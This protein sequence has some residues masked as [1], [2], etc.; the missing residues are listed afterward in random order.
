MM[1]KGI[2][3]FYVVLFAILSL[4]A[5]AGTVEGII[6]DSLSNPLPFCNVYLK[7]TGYTAVSNEIGK[8]MLQ[9]PEGS[10]TIVFQYIGY[11]RHEEEITIPAGTIKLNIVLRSSMTELDVL[12]VRPDKEDPA[13]PII[14]KAISLRPDHLREI[15]GFTC[16]VYMKGLQKLSEAPD[17]IL[18]IKLNTVFD[19]DSNNTGIIYLSE[20]SSNFS[21]KFPDRTKEVMTAS[22]VSGSNSAFSW[23]DAAS[24]QMNF[25][26]NQETLE[27]F[28]QRGFVSPIADN[29]LFFY[30]YQ[31]LDS[32]AVDGHM[33][34]T[35]AVQPKRASDPVY[36]G[37]I[38]ITNDDYR[39]YGLQ[40][41]LVQA[42]GMEFLDTLHIDQEFYYPDREH[43]VTL[44]TRFNF[45]YKFF[46]IVGSGY[47]H[48]YYNN[49][50]INP[51]FPAKYFT[52][53][54]SKI[55]SNANKQDSLYWNSIR[56]M[57]LT[58][59]EKTD[60]K[61]KETLAL[62]KESPAYQ[63][64]VDRAFNKFR[65][66]HLITGYTYRSTPDSIFIRTNP[67]FDLI[68]FNTVELLVFQ[69][70]ISFSKQLPGN[71]RISFVPVVRYATAKNNNV[72]LSGSA[73]YRYNPFTNGYIT[74][75]GGSTMRQFADPGIT[76]LFNSVYTLL[77]EQ[78][79]MK[80]YAEEFVRIE[81]EQEVGINGLYANISG[82]YAKRYLQVNELQDSEDLLV[83]S[84]DRY[85]SPNNEFDGLEEY[86][87]YKPEYD[88][89]YG[90]IEL[91]YAIR[92][93][94]ITQPDDKYILEQ[95]Y[96]VITAGY[97]LAG[98]NKSY[99]PFLYSR[100]NVAF[101]DNIS[102]RLAG[103]LSV[104]LNGS[105]QL[106]YIDHPLLMDNMYVPGNLTIF[107]SL[108]DNAFNLLPYYAGTSDAYLLSAHFQWHT[109]GFLFRKIPGFKELKLQPVF[110]A[111]FLQTP[112]LDTYKEYSA[113]IEHIFNVMRVDFAYSP[114]EFEDSLGFSPWRITVG[115]GF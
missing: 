40:L 80:L 97:E 94:Y 21:F 95:K 30:T 4:H 98:R 100:F 15:D 53:E 34:Y 83:D 96:P 73:T 76:P 58:E 25:Y 32:N 51:V 87:Y 105:Y 35:I 77:L 63:D 78:N 6:T 42:N 7:S 86:F 60:Y 61:E 104:H 37:T 115:F 45:T 56:P 74:L 88:K 13:Y 89:W 79:Y 52:G 72:R 22:K 109:E 38:Y 2:K 11:E 82:G 26:Q 23:N 93:R 103:N 18:G 17:Q 112:V 70:R 9:A 31:L 64:S 10:Y 28:S 66:S 71:R 111:H 47:F 14:R 90:K 27:G 92:Q 107:S 12:V 44:S 33:I 5:S 114:Y 43:L 1:R 68:S 110:G 49:Y 108:N 81:A 106:N 20:S 99:P 102:L 69:P 48:A 19:V 57:Q 67:I 75:S 91:R 113:G 41:T 59:E 24:M 84:P 8:Y 101:D 85:I 50:T 65:F 54:V 55:E 3:A 46:G 36:R 29:A 39:L 16:S 62:L